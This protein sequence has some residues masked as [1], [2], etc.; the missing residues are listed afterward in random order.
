MFREMET[1][2]DRAYPD[3][4]ST[5]KI[6]YDYFTKLTPE[7]FKAQSEEVRTKCIKEYTWDKVYEIW[8]KCF[9]SIDITTKKPWNSSEP[10]TTGN[11]AVPKNLSRYEFIKYV[12]DIIINEPSLFYSAHVQNLLKDFHSGLVAKNGTITGYGQKEV[13][14]IL[15]LHLSSKIANRDLRLNPLLLE[16]KEDYIICQKPKE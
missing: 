5:A 15:E 9:D 4:E 7:S 11:E 1:N 10:D 16:E 14:E 12:C 2:A 6:L 13:I 3:I 8:D